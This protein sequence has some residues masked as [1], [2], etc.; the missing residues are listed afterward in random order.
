MAKEIIG[1]IDV[2]TFWTNTDYGGAAGATKRT[3]PRMTRSCVEFGAHHAD[4][5]LRVGYWGYNF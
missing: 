4:T 5:L 3:G 1:T 2:A